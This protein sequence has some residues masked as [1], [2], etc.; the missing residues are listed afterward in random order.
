MKTLAPLILVLSFDIGVR[1]DGILAQTQ[2][3]D[4]VRYSEAAMVFSG[5]TIQKT[6]PR[7]SFV[8]LITGDN[9]LTGNRM[10]MGRQEAFSLSS[11]IIQPKS[12]SGTYLQCMNE[13]ARAFIP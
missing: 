3:A 7:E 6:M 2:N 5:G 12:R 4:A 8:N 10:L 9:Q 11:S 1:L 13:P